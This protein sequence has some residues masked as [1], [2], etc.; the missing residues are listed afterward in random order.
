VKYCDLTLATPEENLACD[1]ALLDDAESGL[2]SE[3]L[4]VWEPD[5]HFVVLGYANRAGTE[6]NLDFCDR[7][8]IPVLRRCTGG[9]AVLQGPGCLNFSLILRIADPGP[10]QSIST[11]NTHILDRHQGALAPLLGQAV[12]K[13]GQS[14]LAKAGLKFSGNAQRRKQKFI[15]FHGSLL[16]NLDIPLVEKSLPLPSKR[17]AYRAGRSHSDFLLNL[18]LPVSIIKTALRKAWDAVEPLER[19]PH[20]QIASLV[21]EKYSL[22][23]WNLKF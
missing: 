16:V 17:P 13:Q 1:E 10:L 7:E 8:C 15:L 12:E 5:R 4:R 6:V 21:R 23:E 3:V 18:Q 9:G 2:G 19:I 22:A 14:D 20:E 11:T